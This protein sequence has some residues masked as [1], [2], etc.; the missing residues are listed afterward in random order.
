MIVGHLCCTLYMNSTTTAAETSSWFYTVGGYH[1]SCQKLTRHA[2]CQ[3]FWGNLFNIN[4]GLNH[5]RR[6]CTSSACELHALWCSQHHQALHCLNPSGILD[7]CSQQSAA[8]GM[9]H[10]QCR[11][12]WASGGADVPTLFH[13]VIEVIAL[14]GVGCVSFTIVCCVG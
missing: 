5:G 8:A 10:L 3:V 12:C 2:S 7:A 13:L 6:C 14:A 4:P 9:Q 11:E 1:S